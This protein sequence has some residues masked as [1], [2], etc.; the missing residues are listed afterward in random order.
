MKIKKYDAQKLKL[1]INSLDGRYNSYSTGKLL[2][3]NYLAERTRK[4]YRFNNGRLHCLNG[5]AVIGEDAKQITNI[6]WIN[7]FNF[8]T[9]SEYLEANTSSAENKIILKLKY[10]NL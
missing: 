7:G 1:I 6:W 10:I 5:P 2:E 3:G 8:K 4:I 9:F